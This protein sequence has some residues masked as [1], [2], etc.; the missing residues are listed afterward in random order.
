MSDF[1]RETEIFHYHYRHNDLNKY[2]YFRKLDDFLKDEASAINAGF[3]I[4]LVLLASQQLESF[5]FSHAFVTL[6]DVGIK[7]KS[8]LSSAIYQKV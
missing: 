2:S 6:F 5:L 7:V 8:G 4:A 1:S 3:Y